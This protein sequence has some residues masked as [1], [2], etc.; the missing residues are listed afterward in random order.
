MSLSESII[1]LD[2]TID[3]HS[4]EAD[5]T[6]STESTE[7]WN[8]KKCEIET[9]G[10]EI[11]DNLGKQGRMYLAKILGP[12]EVLENSQNPYSAITLQLDGK[13]NN[14]LEAYELAL[15]LV[16][17]LNR[18][19]SLDNVLPS[20]LAT[21]IQ[22]HGTYKDSVLEFFSYYGEFLGTFKLGNQ[23][24]DKVEAKMNE[25]MSNGERCMKSYFYPGDGNPVNLPLPLAVRNT[26]AHSENK[27]NSLDLEG[28]ELRKSIE[29]L[30]SWLGAS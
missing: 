21:A 24:Q 14:R 9:I 29:L 5:L 10:L 4:E 23:R 6:V 15:D 26:I 30:K 28:K 18:I 11:A 8:T 16:D 13:L 22:G 12:R 19:D 3:N 2:V 7:L 25:L 27:R 17:K 1:H 20:M